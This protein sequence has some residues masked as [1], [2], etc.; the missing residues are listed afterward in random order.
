MQHLCY[1]LGGDRPSQTTAF[2]LSN[3]KYLQRIRVVFQA[4]SLKKKNSHVDYT[5]FS[6]IQ[7][8][9]IVKVHGVF[10][11]NHNITASSRLFQFHQVYAR[12]SEEV[13]TPFMQVGTYPTR[14][15]ATLGPSELQPPFTGD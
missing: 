8:K 7:F 12:D 1:N 13:V 14:N 15:F 5:N 11:S 3:I 2:K 9:L 10:P 4:Y 6:E